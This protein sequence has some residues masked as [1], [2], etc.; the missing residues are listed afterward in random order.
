[1]TF[2][3]LKVGARLGLG[4]GLVLL[5]LAI[6]TMVGLS[7]LSSLND[8]INATNEER[9]PKLM[10]ANNWIFR[11]METARHTRNML[12][13]EGQDKIKVEVDAVMDD[14]RARKEYLDQLQKTVTATD[15]KAML[16]TVIETR[17]AY[18]P[19]EDDFLKLVSAGDTAGAKE[20]LLK[21]MR[22]A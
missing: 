17:L 14:K 18:V 6:L 7:R 20:L 12:I 21:S 10:T 4:F 15:E 2:S 11:L 1:M 22:P 16:Q 3:N 9:L 8:D 19:S 5:L 13:L